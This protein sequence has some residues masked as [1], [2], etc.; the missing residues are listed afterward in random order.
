MRPAR[1]LRRRA[2]IEGDTVLGV[3][4]LETVSVLA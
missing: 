2:K 3:K 4:V 1:R